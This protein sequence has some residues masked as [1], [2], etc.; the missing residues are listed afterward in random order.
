MTSK[1][2][3]GAPPGVNSSLNF[4]SVHE[5]RENLQSLGLNKGLTT[6][7]VPDFQFQE[8]TGKLNWR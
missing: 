1:Y 5:S 4:A 8:R 7:E 6:P 3:K 2:L